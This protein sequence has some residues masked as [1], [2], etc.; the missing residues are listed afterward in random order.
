MP[1]TDELVP[2][3]VKQGSQAPGV[4]GPP[5]PEDRSSGPL[6]FARS[7]P[8]DQPVDPGKCVGDGLPV[9]LAQHPLGAALGDA[10]QEQI[11]GRDGRP[12]DARRG[13]APDDV[14][15]T[16]LHRRAKNLLAHA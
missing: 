1:E 9:L 10:I 16:G 5:D 11:P 6:P 13:H 15:H 7:E 8:L 14:I 3:R 4:R 12:A 2:D